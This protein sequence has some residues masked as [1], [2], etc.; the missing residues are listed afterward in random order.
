MSTPRS[1]KNWIST[2][3]ASSGAV[4]TTTP[5]TARVDRA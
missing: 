5:A 2:A 3:E 1:S 4:R